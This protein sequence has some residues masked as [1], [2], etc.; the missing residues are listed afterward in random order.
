MQDKKKKY[1]YS[2]RMGYAFFLFF[3]VVSV[4]LQRT[5]KHDLVNTTVM[6]FF[7]LVL[8]DSLPFNIG[9][10]HFSDQLIKADFAL[11]TQ[12][13]IGLGWVTQ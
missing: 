13:G 4:V 8:Y 1:R 5:I 9:D 6:L 11:P 7:C 3:L 10:N 2:S 12:L